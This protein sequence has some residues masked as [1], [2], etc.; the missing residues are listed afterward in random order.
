MGHEG[1]ERARAVERLQLEVLWLRR[2]HLLNTSFWDELTASGLQAILMSC[3]HLGS[4]WVSS[5]RWDPISRPHSLS[6]MATQKALKLVGPLV[7]SGDSLHDWVLACVN[8]DKSKV[9]HSK[10]SH[11]LRSGGP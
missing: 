8:L 1:Q 4:P 7:R 5:C 2:S 11:Y 6:S 9:V 10:H 3:Q